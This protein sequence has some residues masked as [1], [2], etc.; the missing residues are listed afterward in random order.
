MGG[1][2]LQN[3]ARLFW[4]EQQSAREDLTQRQEVELERCNDTEAAT[5]ATERPEQI[6]LVLCIDAKLFAAG[7]DRF[8]RGHP[9]TGK[10][11]FASAEANAAAERVAGDGD[12]RSGA[13]QCG[14]ALFRRLG[15]EI[16]P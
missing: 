6:G 12:I 8:D 1:G 11:V 14:K 2:S 10:A 4:R 3:L 5:A 13:M 15:H 7:T 16:T 9:V